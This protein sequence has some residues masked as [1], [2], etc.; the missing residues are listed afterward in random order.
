MIESTHSSG[1]RSSAIGSDYLLGFETGFKMCED[2]SL[3]VNSK[4]RVKAFNV[5]NVGV[6][7][8]CVL[9]NSQSMNNV[10]CN[11]N[12]LTEVEHME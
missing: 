12:L 11:R 6:F 7:H 4:R 8:T 2:K 9:L 3:L 1:N 5:P 10:F